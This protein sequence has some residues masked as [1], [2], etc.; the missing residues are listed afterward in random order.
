MK[1]C[2]KCGKEIHEDAVICV[3]CGCLIGELKVK[4]VKEVKEPKEESALLAF[5]LGLLCFIVPSL[6]LII[7]IIC[8]IMRKPLAAKK[9]AKGT[10]WGAIFLGLLLSIL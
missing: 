9:S 4:K 5:F 8:M 3:H 2:S 1:V 6:G 10:I 7:W